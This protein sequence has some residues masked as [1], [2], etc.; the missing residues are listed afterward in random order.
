MEGLLQQIKPRLLLETSSLPDTVKTGLAIYGGQLHGGIECE[1]ATEIV[2]PK[3]VSENF[4]VMKDNLS[5]ISEFT[6]TSAG[7]LS[8]AITYSIEQLKDQ[9]GLQQI[10]IFTSK[11]DTRCG[12]LPDKSDILAFAKKNNLEVQITIVTLGNV[13]ENDKEVY[14]G[15]SDI[16]QPIDPTTD[17]AS[18]I[19]QL[20]SIP[21]DIYE[22]V[23][24]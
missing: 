5:E 4:S 23:Y 19:D 2:P 3:K 20:I 10:I 9:K 1:D 15:I 6:P 24:P 12:D 8:N 17:L 18:Q 16:Y 7:S 14:E 13:S 11:V 21:P 22:I